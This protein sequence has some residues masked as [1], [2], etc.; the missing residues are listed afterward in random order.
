MTLRTSRGDLTFRAW[1]ACG[2]G[3]GFAPLAP[4]T[5]ATFSL[6]VLYGFLPVVEPLHGAVAAITIALVGIPLCSHAEKLLGRDASM[7]V[8]DEFAGFAVAVWALPHTWWIIIVTFFLFRLLDIT[9]P[10]PVGAS[11]RLKGGL[12]VITDDLVAGVYTNLAMRGILA[13]LA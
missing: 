1:F 11:Q 5:V 2:F 4:G 10:F 8:W 9:K 12:G 3:L 6:A 13:L 7:I